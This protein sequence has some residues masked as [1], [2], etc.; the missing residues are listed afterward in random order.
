VTDE[1]SK[2]YYDN[3]PD[4]FQNPEQIRASHILVKVDKDDGEEKKAAAKEKIKLIQH[5]VEEGEDFAQ[6]A[7]ENSEGPSSAQGGDLGYFKRGQMVKEFEDAAFALAP[8][9]VSG[10]VETQFGYH[11]IKVVDKKEAGTISYDTVKNDLQNFLKRLK[12][13]EE[14]TSLVDTLR[15]DATIKTYI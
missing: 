11:L 8:G 15:K 10:I 1:E 9:E 7:R 13:T 2:K 12:L 14:V 3:H 6:L 4:S 5:K